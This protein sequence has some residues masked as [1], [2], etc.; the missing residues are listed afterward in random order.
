MNLFGSFTCFCWNICHNNKNIDAALVR[1][2]VQMSNFIKKTYII[3]NMIIYSFYYSEAESKFLEAKDATEMQLILSEEDLENA[4]VVFDIDVVLMILDTYS[5]SRCSYKSGLGHR[6]NDNIIK[7]CGGSADSKDYKNLISKILQETVLVNSKIPD[8]IKRLQ[9]KGL[10]VIAHTSR[11][12]GQ[13]G[14]IA[15]QEDLI[16]QQLKNLGID[17]SGAFEDKYII[18]DNVKV[19]KGTAYPL[20]KNGILFSG[21]GYE[22]GEAQKAFYEKMKI[23]PKHVIFIDDHD[24]N[25]HSV[26]KNL[27][28]INVPVTSIHYTEVEHAECE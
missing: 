17:F 14:E 12:I 9:N 20:F 21:V 8:I 13:Y 5:F 4:I 11:E 22:K 18:V 7:A 1:F 23:V 15:R 16:I 26:E 2:I 19:K 6:L 25:L 24:K 28:S 10:R 3:F 27:E